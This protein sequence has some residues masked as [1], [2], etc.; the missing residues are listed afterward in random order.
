MYS[1]CD[2]FMRGIR[3]RV[4]LWRKRRRDLAELSKLDDRSLADIGITRGD[5]PYVV[6]GR[7]ANRHWKP[8][9]STPM[10]RQNF[11]RPS[12]Q[13]ILGPSKRK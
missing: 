2:T 11:F 12:D 1:R 7:R 10:Q 8:M 3:D 6:Y 13:A 5:I 4:E 9:E